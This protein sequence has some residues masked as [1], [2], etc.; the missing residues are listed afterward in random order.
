LAREWNGARGEPEG[1]PYAGALFEC[2]SCP[3][4]LQRISQGNIDKFRAIQPF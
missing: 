1:A 3:N 4:S 2:Y